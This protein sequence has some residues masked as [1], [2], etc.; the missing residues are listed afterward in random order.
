MQHPVGHTRPV[1]TEAD[2]VASATAEQQLVA[3]CSCWLTL[4]DAG[5][6]KKWRKWLMA[7]G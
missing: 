5:C 7:D 4:A 6:E 2:L 3:G 1:D